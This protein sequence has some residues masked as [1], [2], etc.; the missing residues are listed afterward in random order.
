MFTEKHF[1]D[2]ISGE[3]LDAYLGKGWYRLGQIV[4][5]SHFIF[6]EE[7]LYSPIWIRLPLGQSE[8]RKSLRKIK[9]KVESSFRVVVKPAKITASK[10]RLY[11]KYRHN[12]NGTIAPTLVNSLQDDH[13][14]NIFDSFNV[15]VYHGRKLIAFS[16]FDIGE[17]SIASIKGVYDP[18]YSNY[19]LGIYTMLREI[20]FGQE[21]GFKFYYPGYIVPGHSR[22]DYKLRIGKKE[23]IEFYDLKTHFWINYANFNNSHIPVE[24]LSKK[25]MHLGRRLSEHDISCQMLFYP[26]YEAKIF[27]YESE[28]FLESPLF[29][30]I[31]NDIFPRP[32]FIVFYDIWKEKLIF[33]HC[34][35]VEDLGFYFECSMQFDNKNAKHF[36]D[37]IMK[38]SKIIESDDYDKIVELANN[39]FSL[40]KK[41]KKNIGFPK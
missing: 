18:A 3:E 36:L 35:A 40:V 37:F 14:T 9:H 7:K 33:C 21:K 38:K 8:F 32:S 25:L 20:E 16:I 26:A 39:I 15:E 2:S 17:N 41:P 23:E 31:F 28:R 24:L 19:S 4:F 10:E 12:F 13:L 27:G 34:M 29:L 30:N 6:F 22:F 1:L 11:Q 5:T